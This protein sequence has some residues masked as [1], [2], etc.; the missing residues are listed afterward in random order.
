MMQNTTVV[1]PNPAAPGLV[2]R[3]EQDLS[4]YS[5]LGATVGIRYRPTPMLAL[6]V[7]YRTTRPHSCPRPGRGQQAGELLLTRTLRRVLTGVVPWSVDGNVLE[8]GR[9]D[10]PVLQYRAATPQPAPSN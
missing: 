10:G 6:A 9:T 5:L 7:S 2:N 4:G 8:L 3:V 1:V